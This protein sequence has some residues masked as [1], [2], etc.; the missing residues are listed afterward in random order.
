[1]SRPLIVVCKILVRA[2]RIADREQLMSRRTARCGTVLV[3]RGP[4]RSRDARQVLIRSIVAVGG[5]SP[6]RI[7]HLDDPS[8][9]IVAEREAIS[10]GVDQA[11]QLVTRI[12]GR[13][14]IP[15]GVFDVVKLAIG[16]KDI[17]RAVRLLQAIETLILRQGR[18]IARR[19]LIGSIGLEAE[20]AMTPDAW[21]STLPAESVLSEISHGSVHP[22]PRG[23]RA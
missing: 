17:G 22:R 10:V 1:M 5:D 13:D 8:L 12:N 4:L 19:A 21:I 9:G 18:V 14:A 6:T 3:S 11:R 23:P 16:A 2:I 7:D 20:D 15:V